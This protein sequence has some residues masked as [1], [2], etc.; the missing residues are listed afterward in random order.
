MNIKSVEIAWRTAWMR[1]LAASLP[2][3]EPTAP[4]DWEARPYRVVYLRDDAIGDLIIAT[5]TIRA[6]AE[7]H[8]TI[9]V[10][11][12]ASHRNYHVLD[13]NPHVRRVLRVD[14]SGR[15]DLASKVRT[16][17]AMRALRAGR[18]DVVVDGR[19]DN[20]PVFTTS[21]LKM[22]GSRAPYRVGAARG[23][24]PAVYNLPVPFLPKTVNYAE[25]VSYLAEPFGVD[26]ATTSFRPELF[27]TDAERARAEAQ[28]RAAGDPGAGRLL[29]NVS[30]TQQIRRWPDERFVESVR[31]A[32][33]RRP[34][35]RVLVIGLPDEWESVRA[36]AAAT[37]AE[38]VATTGVRAA[39][40]L[41]GT[42][43]FVLTPDTGI[44]HAAAA[45]DVP[46]VVMIAETSL[47]YAPYYDRAQ[48]VVSPT[49]TN[50]RD[51]PVARVVDALD[52][53]L[54]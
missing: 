32:Q 2:C 49:G 8:P 35:L 51:T 23:T 19:I 11:V 48:L 27:L 34:G 28:W 47:H 33:R 22:L 26:R 30:A 53:L 1:T 45:F 29:V 7:S 44:S 54:A 9:T 42:S 21:L 12:L 5:G 24:G 18:Y 3:P 40:A 17:L 38:P 31:H 6:I 50:V 52:A 37:G 14:P 46:A 15:R 4:P 39:F 10:D 36:V 43:G 13:G 25:R 20:P 41:V 16:P